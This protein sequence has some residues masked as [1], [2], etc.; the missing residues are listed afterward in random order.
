MSGSIDFA[1]PVQFFL[2]VCL[3]GV[4][5][6]A[7]ATLHFLHR[8]Y[9][10]EKP[11]TLPVLFPIR[12]AVPDRLLQHLPDPLLWKAPSAEAVIPEDSILLV[13]DKC[14]SSQRALLVDS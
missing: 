14:P 4:L 1:V 8:L 11:T 7:I 12:V 6:F 3:L 13:V 10:A 5:C 2:H 9:R